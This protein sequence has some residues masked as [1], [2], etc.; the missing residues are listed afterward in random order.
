M[1]YSKQNFTTGQVLTAE[2]LNNIEKGIVANENAIAEKQ[3]KGDYATEGFVT[4]KIAEAQLGGNGTNVDLSA[5]AKTEDIAKNYQPKGNYLT[6]HQKIKTINGQ[7]MVGEGNIQIA[8]SAP[9]S[10]TGFEGKVISVLGDS[11]SAMQGYIPVEDGFNLKHDPQYTTGFGVDNMWWKIV[12]NRLGAKLGICDAWDGTTV[13]NTA[14]ADSGKSG[15]NTYIGSSTRLINLGSNGTPDMILVFAGT[16][17]ARF[18]SAT[19]AGTF[20]ATKDYSSMTEEELYTNTTANILAESYTA[21]IRKLQYLYPA[22]K[23]VCLAPMYGTPFSLTPSKRILA[24]KV[25]KDVCDYFGT[26]FL[27][28]IKA[29]LNLNN[30]TK[31]FKD[32]IHPNVDGMKLI[33]DFVYKQIRDTLEVKEG[34]N[35]VYAVTN[36][37]DTLTTSKPHVKGISKGATYTANLSGTSDFTGVKI[38]MGTSDVTSSALASDGT[39]TITNVSGAIV[40]A[41][42]DI[43]PPTIQTYSITFEEN[44]GSVVAD[45]TGQTE[46][47][48][49]LPTTTRSGYTFD[50]WYTNSGLTVAANPGATLTA[51]VTLYAKWTEIVEPDD[52]EDGGDS[53]DSGIIDPASVNWYVDYTSAGGNFNYTDS[54]PGFVFADSNTVAA[55]QGVPINAV[56]VLPSGAGDMNIYKV[57]GTDISNMIREDNPIAT[58]VI[59]EED[60]ITPAPTDGSQAKAYRLATTI[61]LANNERLLIKGGTTGDIYVS[62]A[63]KPAGSNVIVGIS[64]S[65]STGKAEAWCGSVGYGYISD[66]GTNPPVEPDEPVDPP[67][68]PDDGDEGGSGGTVIDPISITWYVDNGDQTGKNFNYY[69]QPGAT[70]RMDATAAKLRGVPINAVKLH[71]SKAGVF[72]FAKWV[73]GTAPVVAATINIPETDVY[74]SAPSDTDAARIYLLS[75]TITLADNEYLLC[76]CAMNDATGG[77]WVNAGGGGDYA[78]YTWNNADNTAKTENWGLGVSIGYQE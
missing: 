40:I 61:T 14:T 1:S 3:P 59:L 44:G 17:D 76:K 22:A 70:F 20:D 54:F 49:P 31:Y 46:L 42:K 48:N 36:Q 66:T 29:G 16:N 7:S 27:D 8:A 33:G 10:K 67:V 23:I 28:P 19:S 74:T 52:G 41:D 24:L 9:Q 43:E 58:F 50:G 75:D 35:V 62:T 34:E 25:I 64:A 63:N 11:I 72:N 37:L 47:P 55:M 71:P 18:I 5:Y 65:A 53:G 21:L 6:E 51:N 60:V 57:T 4:D 78:V 56:K 32:G 69:H 15:P 45:L 2:H 12:I 26:L 38:Y 77:L 30:T 13:G 73:P 39:I 68:E